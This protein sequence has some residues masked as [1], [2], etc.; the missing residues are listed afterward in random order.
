LV[1]PFLP[2]ATIQRLKGTFIQK[3]DVGEAF[4]SREMRMALFWAS[5]DATVHHPL[6]GVGP[7]CFQFYQADLAASQGQRGMWHETHNTY[8]QISSDCGIPA[9]IFYISGA[10]MGFSMLR[11]A[12]KS[13]VPGIAPLAT[14]LSIMM[15]GFLACMA[16]LSQAYGFNLLV[17]TGLGISI[18][19]ITESHGAIDRVAAVA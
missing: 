11:R 5:I 10:L 18:K 3:D 6:L 1:L 4:E 9:F 8:T 13:D 17:L 12:S 2:Q 15:L 14:V 7:N 16:F 19:A